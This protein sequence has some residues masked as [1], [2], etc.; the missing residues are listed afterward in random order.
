MAATAAAIGE[1]V[2]PTWP[3]TAV[4]DMARSGR[5]SAFIGHLIDHRKNGVDGVTGTGKEGEEEAHDRSNH[6][7]VLGIGADD[8]CGDANEN[9]KAAR[10]LHAGCAQA[11]R[12]DDEHHINRRRSGNH[13]ENDCQDEKTGAA[14]EAQRHAAVTDAEEDGTEQDDKFYEGY[15]N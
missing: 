4:A 13:A 10:H 5:I 6:R 14:E 15:H 11:D 2:I 8:A 9:I 7:N 3:A 1:A 12:K